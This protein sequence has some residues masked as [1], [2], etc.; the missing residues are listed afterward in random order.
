MCSSHP[1]RRSMLQMLATVPF[2]LAAARSVAALEAPRRR[3]VRVTDPASAL[4]QLLAGNRRYVEGRSQHPD[5]TMARR[6]EVA[7]GQHPIAVVLTCADS[8]VPPE[9]I[10]DQGLG[11]LFTLRVAGNIVDDAVLGSIEFGVEELGVPLVVVLVHERCG[12]VKAAVNAVRDGGAVPG[13]MRVLVDA[14]AP[15]IT[16]ATPEMDTYETTLRRHLQRTVAQVA[17]DSAFL[18]PHI[19]EGRLQVKGARYDLD[20]GLVEVLG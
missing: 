9:L 17:A 14:I 1:D 5:E 8:R 6:K 3:A 7:G 11:D 2:G 10:F 20:T 16:P 18:A 15:A 4:D 13:H 12:A 19:A